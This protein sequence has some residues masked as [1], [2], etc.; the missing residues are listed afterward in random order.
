[1]NENNFFHNYLF[2]SLY[3]LRLSKAHHSLLFS[4]T[5][6][7]LFSILGTFAGIGIA[8]KNSPTKFGWTWKISLKINLKN[9]TKPTKKIFKNPNHQQIKHQNLKP[10]RKKNQI[11]FFSSY[12]LFF[13]L[14][15]LFSFSFS[16]S[17]LREEGVGWRKNKRRRRLIEEASWACKVKE[18]GDW[19]RRERVGDEIK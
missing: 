2:L 7:L 4:L 17:H 15:L 13:D 6:S 5:L 16:S 19:E 11:F 14:L 10:S 8:Q 3:S 1:M 12:I 9:Q 18:E